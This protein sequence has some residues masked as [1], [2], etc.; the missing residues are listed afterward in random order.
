MTLR[1]DFPLN[2]ELVYLDSAATTLT[3]EPVVE[4]VARFMVESGGNYGRGSHRLARRVTRRVESVREQVADFLG[5]EGHVLF[6]R[7]TTEAVNT[8][9]RG[10]PVQGKVVTSAL[11]H[12]SNL[13]PWMREADVCKVVPH[14][15]G[16]L[17]PE[18]FA[19]AVDDETS[20]VAVTQV[21]NV[22]GSVQPVEKIGRIA[23]EHDALF[24]V[25]IAQSAGHM[26]VD[27][28]DLGADLLAFSGHKGMLG[29]QGIGGLCVTDEV[30]EF[31]EPLLLGGGGVHSV[32][33]E[34][35]ELEEVPA[36]F[37]SGTPNIPGVVGLGT[38]LNYLE[39]FG[40]KR[41]GRVERRLA[42]DAAE[43]LAELDGV[44]VHRPGEPTGVVSFTLEGW[45][46]HDVANMLDRM[47]NVCLR[48]G[49]HCAMLS[50]EDIAPRGTIRASF[51]LYNTEEDVD[52]L[53]K[54]VHDVL[55]LG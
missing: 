7:G 16:I 27:M 35:Y 32:T 29:P 53:V 37:E 19:E 38:A 31:M 46:P 55:K 28:K 1:D 20:L 2:E 51:A 50:L 52:A 49:H 48:S 47:A 39:D 6:T 26:H 41:A 22:Y 25:D 34:S 45:N 8:A 43:R 15:G 10:L 18:D 42:D 23:E 17:D 30:A 36:R 3:P 44:T 9:A 21:S 40:L 5:V 54:G 33:T 12:H 14:R 4:E 24:L 11:E 13:V